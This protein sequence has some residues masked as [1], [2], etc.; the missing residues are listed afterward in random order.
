MNYL[1]DK[2]NKKKKWTTLI[3]ILVVLFFV[4]FFYTIIFANLSQAFHYISKP[5]F[6]FK[7]FTSTKWQDMQSFFIS[8]NSLLKE[9]QSLYLQLEE[10][11]ARI[12]NYDII[13]DENLKL[14][15]EFGRT[16]NPRRMIVSAI[17]LKPNKSL[18]DTLIIDVGYKGNIKIGDR[19][20]AHNAVP[21]GTVNEVYEYTSKVVLFSTAGENTEVVIA[22]QDTFM[23]LVG[24]GGGNFEMIIPRD[25]E[26]A[27]G[28][29]VHL[30]GII[31]YVVAKAETIISD[32]RDSV[33]KALLVSPVNIQNLK[34]VQVEL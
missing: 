11:Q 19:V 28:T 3:T 24:R 21:I 16:E 12:A 26:L 4:F 7:N 15:E 18:Y 32:P 29:L 20:F 31:P 13:L 17:L 9:N 22:G 5:V 25:F 2:K 6:S 1:Q 10:Q 30:P 33:K 34:F 27:S 23:N 8:K 14:K